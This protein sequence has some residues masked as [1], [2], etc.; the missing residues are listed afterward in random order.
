MGLR[1]LCKVFLGHVGLLFVKRSF[2]K[3]F[4]QVVG[5]IEIYN[6]GRKMGLRALCKVGYVAPSQI[7]YI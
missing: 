1:V 7:A 5:F 3:V 2:L 6:P 4:F